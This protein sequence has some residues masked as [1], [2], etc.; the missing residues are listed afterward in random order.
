MEKKVKKVKVVHIDSNIHDR[1]R[2]YCDVNGYKI[3]KWLEIQ[4]TRILNGLDKKPAN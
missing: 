1:I 2:E 4:L 3:N